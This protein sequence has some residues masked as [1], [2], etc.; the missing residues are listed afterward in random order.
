MG[1]QPLQGDKMYLAEALELKDTID[2]KIIELRSI[3]VSLARDEENKK[4]QIDMAVSRLYELVEQYQKQD[5]LI[6]K[7]YNEVNITIGGSEVSI[8]NAIIMLESMN[9]KMEILTE[10]IKVLQNNNVSGFDI[11]KMLNDR[12]K[13]EKNYDV[14]D[15]EIESCKW[16]VKL[17]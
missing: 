2:A 3:L 7:V 1:E 5:M 9:T 16:R 12:D 11:F 17:S 6:N 4:D 10:L 14:I 8:A 13:I 15:A